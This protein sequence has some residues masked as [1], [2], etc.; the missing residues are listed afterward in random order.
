MK[1]EFAV[2]LETN[3][4]F[5][6]D[7][8]QLD[9]ANLGFLETA[10]NEPV[11]SVSWRR[12]RDSIFDVF[13]A[14]SCVVV[15]DNA[16][17]VL[18]ANNIYS[19]LYGSLYPG[20]SITVRATYNDPIYGP[21]FVSVFRGV[22][23]SYN[24]SYDLDG[25]AILSITCVDVF[26]RLANVNIDS[27]VVPAELS[28]ARVQRILDLCDV[29]GAYQAVDAGYTIC[30]AETLTNVRAL[31]HLNKVALSEFGNLFVTGDGLVTFKQRNPP[32]I[33]GALYVS[34]LYNAF[35]DDVEFEYSFD[36]ITNDVIL[37]TN[38]L[39]SAAT[40]TASVA[41]Y[42]SR[43]NVFDLT[44]STQT[45]LDKLAAGYVQYLGEP[46]MLCRSASINFLAIEQVGDEIG[47]DG[48]HVQYIGQTEIGLLTAVSWQPPA[49]PGYTVSGIFNDPVLIVAS[50][51]VVTPNSHTCTIKLDYALGSNAFL[52]DDLVMGVLD[53]GKLGL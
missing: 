19:P 45:Q 44:V 16:T 38:T 13:S 31:D 8:D 47:V 24:Y 32:N 6:L 14:G 33:Y 36:R 7:V 25:R 37:N 4:G 20:R 9:N 11:L 21:S 22:T 17:G 40:N 39:T 49:A 43:S 48:L 28:G 41:Q 29:P 53:Y 50:E 46:E 10:I 15:F 5:V 34:N 35:I 42:G 2:S 12:G 23:E 51:H 52:L 30:E 18:D 26:S 3:V 1:I 27:L